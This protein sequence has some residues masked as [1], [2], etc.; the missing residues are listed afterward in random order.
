[1]DGLRP[2]ALAQDAVNP[3]MEAWRKHPCF[4]H[5]HQR[6]IPLTSRAFAWLLVCC[7]KGKRA[8]TRAPCIRRRA[9]RFGV[10]TAFYQIRKPSTK[11]APGTKPVGGPTRGD[12]GRQASQCKRRKISLGYRTRT[13]FCPQW[14]VAQAHDPATSRCGLSA[15]ARYF[16]ARAR[17]SPDPGH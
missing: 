2:E 3:S 13:A 9:G 11:S 10:P 15:R 6:F 5:L 12:A 7:P 1:M 16:D 17:R 8:K 4:Q 14:A